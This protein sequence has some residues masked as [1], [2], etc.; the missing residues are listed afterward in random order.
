MLEPVFY[1][2]SILILSL[3]MALNIN[4]IVKANGGVGNWFGAIFSFA[5]MLH[6]VFNF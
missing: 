3:C 1:I 2:I 4:A 6:F 5:V